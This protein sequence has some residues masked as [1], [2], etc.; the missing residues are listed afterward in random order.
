MTPKI[1][2]DLIDTLPEEAFLL[3]WYVNGTLDPEDKA[4]V[5]AAL[6]NSAELREE[7]A[8]LRSVNAA[9]VASTDDMPE[10]DPNGFAR[11]MAR[12]DAEPVRRAVP[13]KPRGAGFF[14]RVSGMFEMSWKP[15]MTAAALLIAVQAGAIVALIGER[16]GTEK[17]YS[18]A[19]GGANQAAGARF[20]VTFSDQAT[21][22]EMRAALEAADVA[23][24]KGPT[25]DGHFV[26]VAEGD[27]AKASAA[28]QSNTRIVT[29]VER[30]Q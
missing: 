30:M 13:A 27:A 16:A 23:I 26:V 24:V 10:P 5:E 21:L 2:D 12:I 14:A 3:P 28:L 15:I 29:Q 9:V 18:T 7:L 20:L 19:S 6:A 11:L 17:S 25:A 22:A 4:R 8:L 1:A